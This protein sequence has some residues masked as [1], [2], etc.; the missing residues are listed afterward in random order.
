MSSRIITW[1]SL[2]RISFNCSICRCL[3]TSSVVSFLGSG[4]FSVD[5]V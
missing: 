2:A 1:C 5:I 4:L 3:L